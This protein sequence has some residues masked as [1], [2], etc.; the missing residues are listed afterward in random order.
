MATYPLLKGKI[1][2]TD[3]LDFVRDLVVNPVS[4]LFVVN[5]DEDTDLQG[6]NVLMGACLLPPPEAI[7]AE[8]DGDEVS[9]DIIY[10]MYFNNPEVVNFMAG[11]IAFLYIG[12]MLVL[13]Y[14]SL[15]TSESVTMT[16]MLNLIWEKFGIGIGIVNL[17]PGRYNESYLP[18]WLNILYDNYVITTDEFLCLMPPE[19]ELPNEI[20]NRLLWELKPFGGGYNDKLLFIKDLM[21]KKKQNPAVRS[22][23]FQVEKEGTPNANVW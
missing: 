8:V 1:D 13:Y 4:K 16:K 3:N 18:I 15:D 14:P 19:V 11:L 20:N 9:Y 10:N 17:V 12:G 6:D 2:I 5:L 7:M 23:I 21:M 22:P